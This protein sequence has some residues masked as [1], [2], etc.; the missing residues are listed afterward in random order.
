[1][2]ISQSPFFLLTTEIVFT[3]RTA[4]LHSIASDT[5]IAP[6]KDLFKHM[7]ITPMETLIRGVDQFLTD[8]TVSGAVAEIHGD[9]VTI[10]P[11][12]EYV[13]EDSKRNIETFWDLGYA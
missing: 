11:P 1:V 13:D 4:D 7:T 3:D 9:R 10:R 2:L 12:H 5:N 8:P 6:N